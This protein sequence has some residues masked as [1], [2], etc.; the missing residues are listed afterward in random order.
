MQI[1][2]EELGKLSEMIYARQ[3][4]ALQ[5]DIADLRKQA[6]YWQLRYHKQFQ[7][8]HRAAHRPR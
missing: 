6:D 3:I 1:D 7:C 8:A 5:Q 4:Q 2:T